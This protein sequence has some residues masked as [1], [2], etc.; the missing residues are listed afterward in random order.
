MTLKEGLQYLT[1]YY[2]GDL[3][4]KVIRLKIT[5]GLSDGREITFGESEYQTKQNGP[6]AGP[7]RQI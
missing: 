1:K 3:D 7:G 6:E 2:A 4:K 5:V